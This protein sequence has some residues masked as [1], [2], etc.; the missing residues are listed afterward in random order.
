MFAA[1][2]ARFSG[3]APKR[4]VR[5]VMQSETMECGLACLV[6]VANAY[7]HDLDLPYLRAL[8]PPSRRGMTFAEIVEVAGQ[9]G[10]DA[11]GLGVSNIG[12]LAKVNGPAILHWNGNHF[13]VLEKVV[14]GAFHVHDPAFGPRI[15][16]RED[17][18]R[19]FG[20]VA[21]EFERRIDFKAVKAERKSLF[22]SVYRC[23]RGIEHT[24]GMIA[25]LSFAATLFTLATPVFLQTAIDTV[26]PQYDLDLLTV[27]I[28]GLI[29]FSAFEAVSR[30]LRDVITL[31]AATM[32]EIHF[33]RNIVGHALRL[34]LGFFEARHP[35]DFVTRLNSVDHIKTFL[36]TGFVSSIA[37]G[38][39]TV[40]L[41]GMMYYYSP[42][43][44]A[45]SLATLVAAILVRFAT[46]PEI[47][48]STAQ[49]LES[50]SEEQARLLDGLGQIAA[51]KVSNSGS[52]FA[53]KWLESFTRFANFSYR[54]KKLSIDADLL[55]HLIFML[56]TVATLYMGVTDVMK[57]ILSVGVLY[58][59]FALRTSFFNSMNTLI[60]SLLQLS[61]MRVHFGRLDDVLDETPEPA[62][63][64]VHI[65]RVIRRNV[66]LED[67]AVQF[68][69]GQRPLLADVN[70]TIDI[71]R[72]ET[73]AIIGP[74]GCGKSSLLRILASLHPAP[75]GQ[76]LVDGRALDAF[77]VHEYRANIGCVFADDS[78]FAGTVAENVAL[79]APDVGQARIEEALGLVGL[80]DAIQGLPQGYATM[81]SNESPLLST[82]QR[83][84]L[85]LA[86]ALCRRPRLL[87]LDEVTANLDPASEA[88][89][90]QTLIRYPT[91]KVFVTHSGHVLPFADRVLKVSGGRLVDVTAQASE[92]A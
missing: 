23:C 41:I 18:E 46:Y 69:A 67:V 53:L 77:G 5:T 22:W 82:G 26:I 17:M 79:H 29:L 91:A 65:A 64:G 24:I 48:R 44:T 76:V 36:V 86:R 75:H 34:P 49:S 14:R 50:R 7:R 30:W 10:L 39:M 63:G 72:N 73:V 20:G 78:L 71:A 4:P 37:D 12:E 47:A 38:T 84:R 19:H 9:I 6:M 11:Q 35:G 42:T 87:L 27:V 32:F 15:Y 80:L 45:A 66:S 60:M 13:V 16:A 54:S 25:V 68:G 81:L 89:L 33:T 40:L 2:F 8:F 62:S 74:S 59:F 51:L 1:T 3:N 70:L 85:I 88:D 28:V 31:R 52:F 56:G 61:V 58:A 55:L 21:L 90:V 92:A 57:S 83:R 43:M